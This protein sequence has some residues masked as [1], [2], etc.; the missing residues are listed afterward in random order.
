MSPLSLPKVTIK[1]AGLGP[2]AGGT[3]W[4]KVGLGCG[5]G[6]VAS[7]LG[8]QSPHLWIGESSHLSDRVTWG[9]SGVMKRKMLG[10]QEVQV[11]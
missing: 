8:P 3:A 7:P 11:Q 5:A 4:R 1:A 10:T 9:V 6:P 2:G